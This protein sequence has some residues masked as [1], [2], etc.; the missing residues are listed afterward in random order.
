MVL[1]KGWAKN[2]YFH[3]TK[4]LFHEVVIDNKA[5]EIISMIYTLTKNGLGE[6]TSLDESLAIYK[7]IIIIPLTKIMIS[8]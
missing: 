8:I 3:L 4:L 6:I 1:N 5:V 7:I 2:L